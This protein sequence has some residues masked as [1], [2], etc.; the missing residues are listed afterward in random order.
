MSRADD[1]S[2]ELDEAIESWGAAAHGIDPLLAS[3]TSLPYTTARPH[4]PFYRFLNYVDIVDLRRAGYELA[5]FIPVFDGLDDARYSQAQATHELLHIHT[6][7][8]GP[9]WNPRRALEIE[10]EVRS[11]LHQFG[12]SEVPILLRRVLGF[13]FPDETVSHLSVDLLQVFFWAAL[14]EVARDLAWRDDRLAMWADYLSYPVEIIGFE[15][16]GNKA[17]AA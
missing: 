13:A 3:L 17:Q 4:V 6:D 8:A 15:I 16:A 10:F 9:V 5:K 1:F 2:P 12:K 11:L 14:A 7:V